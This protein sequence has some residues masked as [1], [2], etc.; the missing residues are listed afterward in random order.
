MACNRPTL[1]CGHYVFGVCGC[2][3]VGKIADAFLASETKDRETLMKH[4]FR[5][6][7]HGAKLQR[8][9]HEDEARDK[10]RTLGP[11]TYPATP[12]D[13]LPATRTDE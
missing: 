2:Y 6:F 11:P 7:Q 12:S 13:E 10:G 4:L 8:E 5:A 1:P 9:I 3:E